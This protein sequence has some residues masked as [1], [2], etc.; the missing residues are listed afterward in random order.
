MDKFEALSEK[1]LFKF[2]NFPA[3]AFFFKKV[4]TFKKTLRVVESLARLRYEFFLKK[5]LV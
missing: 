4:I 2:L 5:G 3:S 1:K